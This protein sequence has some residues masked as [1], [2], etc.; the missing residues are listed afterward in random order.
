MIPDPDRPS[1]PSPRPVSHLQRRELQAPIAAT[2]I[3]GFADVLGRERALDIAALAIREDAGAAGRETGGRAGGGIAELERLVREVWSAEDAMTVHFLEITDR[4]L[5]FDVT[6]CRYAELY[7][8]LG[9]KDLGFVLSCS[10]DEPFARGF[11]PRLSLR[12]TQ[13]IMQGAR[14]CDFRFTLE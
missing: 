8:R 5:N 12:R 9:I 2:L 10:R 1:H 7:Q 4:A 6:R 13:T 3:R 14:C 11:N